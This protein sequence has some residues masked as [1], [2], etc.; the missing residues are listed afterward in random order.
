METTIILTANCIWLGE[1]PIIKQPYG[2]PWPEKIGE[3][4]VA[5]IDED[6]T[7]GR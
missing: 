4:F 6:E 1:G 5:S 3:T 7:N 2:K